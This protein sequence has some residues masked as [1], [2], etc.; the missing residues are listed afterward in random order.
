[1]AQKGQLVGTVLGG[2]YRLDAVLGFGGM[3]EVYRATQITLG[4]PVAVKVI[5]RTGK[6]A[7]EAE[8]FRREALTVSRLRSPF[9]V[10]LYDFGEETELLYMVMEL[11]LGETLRQRLKRDPQPGVG[12][13]L[14][15][16]S[17]TLQSLDEAHRDGVLHRDI[18]PE[19]LFLVAPV[20]E[21]GASGPRGAAGLWVKVLDFGLAK[22]A[23][24]NQGLTQAGMMVGTPGY[25]SPEQLRGQTLQA[26]SDLYSLACVLY[27]SLC[28]RRAFEFAESLD[29]KLPPPPIEAYPP[30]PKEFSDLI[31]LGVNA[32]P[33]R[34]PAST[35]D[36]LRVVEGLRAPL[37]ESE[38]SRTAQSG[39]R[40]P[41]EYHSHDLPT[42]TAPVAAP[43]RHG[44]LVAGFVLGAAIA[45]GI[46]LAINRVPNLSQPDTVSATPMVDTTTP[47]TPL[48]PLPAETTI[49]TPPVAKPT[50][51]KAG[52]AS[53]PVADPATPLA[54]HAPLPATPAPAVPEPA[55]PAKP[56]H[57]PAHV[58]TPRA[59]SATSKALHDRYGRVHR[60]W[61]EE[62]THRSADDQRFFNKMLEGV[63]KLIATGN[64]SEAKQSLDEF[65]AQ[66]LRGTEP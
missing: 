34:R 6:Y 2:K 16:A 38:S 28:G 58:T 43:K 23:G 17:Q 18:K 22:I 48:P 59:E 35:T 29:G 8:R 12:F 21:G 9:T 4:R 46:G 64:T 33:A 13:T 24:S 56:A 40:V 44:L 10:T 47:A 15:L 65:V 41:A 52:P 45:I 63:Q 66:A 30:T 51:T 11:L 25:M 31:M 62:R 39:R 3:G 42:M 37:A 32:D 50:E 14:E 53:T 49:Q 57:T 27:E 19:N 20:S 7:D 26:T 5:A 1:M 54:E 60:A 61:A 55:A 36:W